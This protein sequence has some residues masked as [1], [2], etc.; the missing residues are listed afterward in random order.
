MFPFQEDPLLSYYSVPRAKS[1]LQASYKVNEIEQVE[2][3][4]YDNCYRFIYCLEHGELL[5]KQA[6]QAPIAVQPVLAFYGLSHLLKAC[7]LTVDP[8]YPTS[9]QVLAHGL[10]SRK[11]KKQNYHFFQDEVKIQRHGLFIHFSE[12]MFHTTHIEG[13][14][15]KMK[16]LLKQIPE[17][18]SLF[19]PYE[20]HSTSIKSE[21]NEETIFYSELMIYY[22]LLYNL[23]M[24]ARYETE[25]WYELLKLMPGEEY[26]FIKQFLTISI[27]KTPLLIEDYLRKGAVK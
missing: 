19:L 22:A 3:C 25:W 15:L 4:A 10:S 9:V 21:K 17:L 11:K 26:P 13:T 18:S 16:T 8:F 5:L 23:S 27:H 20:K 12:K 7:L 6:Q 24:I 2:Q 14:K 1:F